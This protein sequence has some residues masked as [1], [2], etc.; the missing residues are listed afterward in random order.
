MRKKEFSQSGQ[1]TLCM[2]LHKLLTQKLNIYFMMD[3][4]VLHNILLFC[5][6][7][8]H[9]HLQVC[10]RVQQSYDPLISIKS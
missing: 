10:K 7:G 4:C 2:N 1:S 6:L 8:N 3:S 5:N 9:L